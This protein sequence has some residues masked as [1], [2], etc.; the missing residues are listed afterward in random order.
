MSKTRAVLALVAAALATV[1]LLSAGCA[2]AGGADPA[3]L[4]GTWTVESFGAPTA[5][6]PSD[7]AVTTE[8]T[9][10]A[11]TVSGNGGVNS[12]SGTYEASKGGKISFGPTASTKM[13]G[14]PEAMT[15]ETALFK[16]L[17]EAKSFEFKDGKLVLS[18]LGNST[19]VVLAPR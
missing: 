8:I 4:E 13:A 3:G 12:F 19:L 17:S 6:T 14:P 7:P 1:A 5:L 16:A 18:D 11:G 9:F 15:Q 10:K 2:S